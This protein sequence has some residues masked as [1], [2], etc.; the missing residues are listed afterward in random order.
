MLKEIEFKYPAN[1]VW[2]I[3]VGVAVVL[4][5]IGLRKKEKIMTLLH[6]KPNVRFK[7][8]WIVL[9]TTG[10][11]LLVVALM[12]PQVF[13]GYVEI[14]KSGLDIYVLIDTSK[15]MLVMD[16]VPDRL[17]VA[18]RIVSSLLEQLAGDRIGFI[19]FASDAYIQLPLTDDYQLASMFLNVIDTDIISGGGT[20][21]AAAINLAAASFSRTSSADKVILILSDGE[22]H[23]E[24]SLNVVKRLAEEQIRIYA[25]G[26]GTAMG[27]L[28]PVFN[29][30][31]DT[32]TGYLKDSNGNTVVSKLNA[33][34]LRQ[35]AQAGNG[36]YY[37]ASLDGGEIS[38]LLR[39]L[40]AL[41][42]ADYQ[43]TAIKQF[44][45]LYQYFLG[46]GLLLFLIAWLLPERRRGA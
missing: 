16:I 3:L 13:S 44:Q 27:G 8:L 12:G 28:V 41:K 35:L 46:A 15:S 30:A 2:L 32:I 18:K 6:I 9:L 21:L 29:D 42:R 11:V 34:I 38:A 36:S 39:D 40:A 43:T 33:D 23:D 5:I 26:I 20:N 17:T 22:E 1:S 24:A 14:N 37:Q 25:V 19:P 4:Y 7:V 10:L 31:G 45:Q